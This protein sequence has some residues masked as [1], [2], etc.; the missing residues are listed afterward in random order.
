VTTE[1]TVLLGYRIEQLGTPGERADFV[2]RIMDHLL[3]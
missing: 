3:A 1:D 2:G